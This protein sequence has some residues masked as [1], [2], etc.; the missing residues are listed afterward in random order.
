MRRNSIFLKGTLNNNDFQSCATEPTSYFIKQTSHI[1]IDLFNRI[2]WNPIKTGVK[3]KTRE[4]GREYRK[5]DADGG[6]NLVRGTEEKSEKSSHWWSLVHDF[7]RP[8][9]RRG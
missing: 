5:G 2:Y 3:G 8:R 9:A 4:L 7:M 6:N 1:Q